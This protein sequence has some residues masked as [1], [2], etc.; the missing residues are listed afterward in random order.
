[1]TTRSEDDRLARIRLMLGSEKLSR[2]RGSFA[3]VVGLGA[4]GSY[5]VE[6]RARAG[7]GRLRLVDF[8]VVRPSNINRQLY[9]ASSTVGMKKSEV[10]RSRVLD[11]NPDCRAEALCVFA[12]DLSRAAI[13]E[14]KIDLV[15]DAI[16]SLGPKAALVR[17]VTSRGL[18]LIS[19]MGA[20]LR[21]DP[22]RVRV[23]LF[24]EVRKCPLAA[25]LRDSLTRSG[26]VPEFK[27]VYSD[28]PVPPG[29]RAP[30]PEGDD[31]QRRHRNA[32][33]GFRALSAQPTS[34]VSTALAPPDS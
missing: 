27:C 33:R 21:T 3:V 14:G 13:L 20:A 32:L 11:I 9:A 23:G 28:E 18:P 7:V 4:V 34:A 26:A 30:K 16:D 29:R 19:S 10:A 17:D 2:L 31:R 5:A 1:M 24:S 12:D 8:D 6:G 22:A 25:R 15:I